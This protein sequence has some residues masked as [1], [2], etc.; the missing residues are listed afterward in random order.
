[1]ASLITHNKFRRRLFTVIV[2]GCLFAPSTLFAFRPFITDDAG[3][4]PH[5][6]FELETA[7]D[8]WHNAATFGLCFKHGITER[9]DLGIAFG[10]CVL[11][12][13]EGGYD[14]AELLLKF[15]FVPDRFSASFSG[16]FGKHHYNTMLIYSH[17]IAWFTVHANAG[18]SAIDDPRDGFF[19]YGLAGVAQIKRFSVG[20]ELGGTAT[21]LD[22]W[23]FGLRFEIFEWLAID[24]ALGGDFESDI[25]LLAT[26]GLFFAFPLP[27][28]GA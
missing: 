4:V 27:K 19:T 28:K 26:S 23:Q 10:R 6:T 24:A 7:A 12:Q 15:N 21:D 3:T 16:S 5:L 2:A 18:L 25:S 22:W 13:D 11:P 9:M 1:M 8:Y 14:P 20:A 17:P